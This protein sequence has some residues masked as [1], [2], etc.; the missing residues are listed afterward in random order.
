MRLIGESLTNQESIV[1]SARVRRRSVL[2][3]GGLFDMPFL[4]AWHCVV[5]IYKMM[6]C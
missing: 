4:R 1:A 6:S 5:G 3:S 2:A